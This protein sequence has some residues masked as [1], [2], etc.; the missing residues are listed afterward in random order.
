MDTEEY[1]E[2]DDGYIV[3][4]GSEVN[5]KHNQILIEG[6]RWIWVWLIGLLVSIYLLR[7]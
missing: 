6:R 1:V 5:N 4:I 7:N 3:N 2:S